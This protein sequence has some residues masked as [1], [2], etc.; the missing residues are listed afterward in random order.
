MTPLRKGDI[1]TFQAVVT[2]VAK[3]NDGQQIQ[4]K[5]LPNGDQ[6]GWCVPNENA[7]KPEKLSIKV[8]DRVQFLDRPGHKDPWEIMAV[9]DHDQYAIKKVG[10]WPV[11]MASGKNMKRVS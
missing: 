5:I 8:G 6:L 9:F 4:A 10:N 3:F 7:F 2:D 11:E 1:V